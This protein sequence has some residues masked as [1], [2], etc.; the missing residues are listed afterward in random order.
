M[1]GLAPKCRG[2]YRGSFTASPTIPRHSRPPPLPH[3][4]KARQTWNL[5]LAGATINDQQ[6]PP[7]VGSS[8]QHQRAHR[9]ASEQAHDKSTGAPHRPRVGSSPRALPL[10]PSLIHRNPL[11][12]M[13][14]LQKELKKLEERGNYNKAIDHVQQLIDRLNATRDKIETEPARA[15]L[16]L[17]SLKTPVKESHEKIAA[18]MKEISQSLN[19]YSKAL[20]KKFKHY[21]LPA[22]PSDPDPIAPQTHLLNR[23]IAMHLLREGCFSVATSFTHEASL[24]RPTPPSDPPFKSAALQARF[25]SMYT[26]LH[27]LRE[28]HNVAPAIAWARSNAPALESRASNLEFELCR[29]EFVRLFT[30]GAT[31]SPVAN[32][33]DGPLRAWAY[34]RSEFGSFQKRYQ[35]EVQ[36]LVGAMAFWPNVRDSPYRGVFSSAGA[37]DDVA[38]SFMKEF[39]ALLGLSADSPLYVTATAG[40]I[41]LPVLNKVRSIM[42][43]KR[44]EWTTE[45][46]LPVEIPLPPAYHF[47]SIFVCPVS[48]EQATD[49]NPPM[50]MPCGH[51]ICKESLDK[52]SKGTRFKCPYCP[53]ESVPKD[54]RMVYL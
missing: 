33:A 40:A 52:I 24:S 1:G 4:A 37:W 45:D 21:V 14:N 23:A 41:A 5:R 34:M 27:E 51:V 54:A 46:E 44:T 9:P 13:D 35:A 16:L 39:C 15:A 38:A 6:R 22:S 19:S 49:A 17:S 30:G 42:E 36:Q 18:D 8:T 11:S 50:M 7:N 10:P 48:K 31:A 12:I 32:P 25:T 20:D 43:K 29:L 26:I 47:H 53:N 2:P 3:S 28:N